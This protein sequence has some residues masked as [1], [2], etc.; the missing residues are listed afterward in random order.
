MNNIPLEILNCILSRLAEYTSLN[1]DRFQTLTPASKRGILSARV[2]W[3]AYCHENP[4]RQLFVAILEEVPFTIS[5]R[6]DP[7]GFTSRLKELSRSEYATGLTTLSFCPMV[8]DQSLKPKLWEQDTQKA[9]VIAV[10]RFLNVEHV[11]YHT[12]P[13][14][15]CPWSLGQGSNRRQIQMAVP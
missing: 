9:L 15:F 10:K 7:R 13:P 4:L 12:L 5:S 14:K 6:H 8:Y 11:R 3:S 1:T 2:V